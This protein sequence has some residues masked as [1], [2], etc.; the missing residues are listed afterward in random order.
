MLNALKNILDLEL[1]LMNPQNNYSSCTTNC[2]IDN[3]KNTFAL[4]K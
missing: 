2:P 4:C 1:F 3:S